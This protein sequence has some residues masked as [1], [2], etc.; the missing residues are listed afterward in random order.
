VDAGEPDLSK[1]DTPVISEEERK[2]EVRMRKN[3]E[4]GKILGRA[5]EH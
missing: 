2:E 3:F 5:E 4:Q 1:M